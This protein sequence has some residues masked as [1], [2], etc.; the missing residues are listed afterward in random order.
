MANTR[1]RATTNNAENNGEKNNNQKAN[2][3]PPPPP[4][5]EQVLAMQAQMLQAMQQTMV[6]LHAQPKRHHHR[7]IGL[8]IFSAPSH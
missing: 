4:T 5:L 1:N 6:N 8:E 3:P 7:G 2:P